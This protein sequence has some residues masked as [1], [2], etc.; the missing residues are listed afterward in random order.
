M[1]AYILQQNFILSCGDSQGLMMVGLDM[2]CD[3]E[4]NGALYAGLVATMNDTCT[5]YFSCVET[6]RNSNEEKWK[7]FSK[8]ITSKY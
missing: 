3:K 5:N 4:N 1:Y 8:S 2:R 7:S 6:P